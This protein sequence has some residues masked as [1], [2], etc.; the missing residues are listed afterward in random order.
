MFP[1]ALAFCAGAAAL[2]ALPALW[3]PAA[4]SVPLLVACLAVRRFPAGAAFL[5]GFAWCH[6]LVSPRLEAGWPCERDRE[7]LVLTG[8]VAA[9]AIERS[10]RTDFD[11]EVLET[12]ASGGRPGRV[13]LSWYEARALPLPGERWRMTVRLRCRRGMANPGAADRELDLLR[14]RIDAT[15]YVVSKHPAVRLSPPSER[16]IERLRSRVSNA[17]A[18]A[19]PRGPSVAVLQG[20]SVG[21]RGNI[22]DWLWEAFA[23]TGVAHLMAI[24]GL[25]VTGCA[26]FALAL[27]RL[28]W[29]LPGLSRVPARLEIESILVV[30]VT[31]GYA[32]LSGAS[33]P[34]L[35]TLAMVGL[36]AGLR[37]LRRTLPVH[38]TLSLAA[39][40]LVAT[41][42][43][44]LTSGGFWLSFVATAA[45][46]TI[47]VRNTDWRSRVAGFARAQ[48]A[49]AALLAPV[50]VA[51]FGRVSVVAPA[52][53][54]V[55]IPVFS[56]VLLPLVLAATLIEAVA[57]GGAAVIWRALAGLLDGAWP[58]L[59]A[60]AEWPAASWAP[61]GQSAPLIAAA[62]LTLL[63]ALLLPVN[64]SRLAALAMLGAVTLGGAA[65]P[66]AGAWS[67]TAVDV[68]Q[69][70]AVVVETARHVL[71]FDTGARWQGGGTAARVSLLPYLRSRGIRRID[72][73]IVSH[74]D[75]DHSGGADALRQSLK[76]ART[77]T[78]PGSRLAADGVC[79]RGDA[80]RWDDIA[81]RVLHPRADAGGSE[82]DRS[83]ALAVAGP[84]GRA[85]LLADTEAAAESLLVS[86]PIA[87]DVVVLPHH[88]SRS[89]S[90]QALV[91]S[92]SARLGIASAGFGN[93][94]GMPSAEVVARWR[95]AGT[96][97]LRTAEN[98]AIS[99]Q[100]PARPGAIEVVTE[101]GRAGR[102]WRQGAAPPGARAAGASSRYHAAP[103]GKSSS[104]AARSCG[105][106]SC[107]RS[108]RPRSCWNGCGRCSASA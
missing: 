56:A 6:V 86:M 97:V 36:V 105:R 9:P 58:W 72:L 20:L 48:A 42:P 11:L 82:N 7:E 39:L 59:A 93:R 101:R 45:L 71:V 73:L 62:G 66:P 3:P 54:A 102:W 89:S 41:D 34:A 92:V 18:T 77:M 91:E 28:A 50:L 94:W 12:S 8:R 13:R 90:T 87:S 1:I 51:A 21:V 81:F 49:I 57:P 40:V 4:L 85:L 55:A 106:S 98:G 35:R 17:I 31:T 33:L 25:H 15:G 53:N 37:L 88:G 84:G 104:R 76:V 30:A 10:G 61:A 79:R 70:L 60:I 26:V 96:T 19:L 65:R 2:H 24:S 14:Q 74:D 69:G 103:C 80:W 78:A 27:L 67:L 46:L 32:F 5:L 100:F 64:G 23:I 63:A 22:P 108:S 47:L 44:A 83:C 95:A 16:P 52:V 43:L 75:V 38:E 107:A 29:R 99:V 68:G